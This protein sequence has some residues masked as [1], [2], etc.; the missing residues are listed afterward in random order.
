MVTRNQDQLNPIASAFR[1]DG[2]PVCIRPIGNGHIND[3]YLVEC[4]YAETGISESAPLLSCSK[5]VLQRINEN[6]FTSPDDLMDNIVRVTEHLGKGLR[7]IPAQSGSSYIRTESGCWRMMNYIEGSFAPETC[8]DAAMFMEIGRAYGS[9]ISD[10]SDFPADTLHETIENFHDTR[11][12]FQRFIT[13][14]RMD[15]A[16][17]AGN[18]AEEICFAMEHE[19]DVD[20][21]ND[22][23][24]AGKMPLRVTHNDTKINNV[25]LDRE[26][27][28]AICVIDLDTVMPGLAVNDFG[29]AIRS[30]AATGREDEADPDTVRLDLDLYRA[31]AKGFTEGFPDMTESE[32]RMLPVGAGMMTLEC[33]IRFLTDYLEGDNYFK[34]D[35]PE[36]NLIRCRTQFSLLRDMEEKMEDMNSITENLL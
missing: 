9:F 15:I 33:G 22:S 4:S 30:G 28:K 34:T 20:T 25:L 23:L 18:A 19:R 21:L 5:Y 36:H 3:T 10:L 16:G 1:I 26:T 12:R 31:F 24:K 32:I 13:A 11:Q 2:T 17:R 14:C 35:Y 8:R 6:V 27:E 7:V 29:D